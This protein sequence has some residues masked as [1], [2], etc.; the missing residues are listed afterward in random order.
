MP[1]T[2]SVSLNSNVYSAG[3]N[4]APQA[5]LTVYN[6]GASPVTVTSVQMTCQIAGTGQVSNVCLPGVPPIGPGMAVTVPALSSI[7]I[8]PW[9]IAVVSAAN[10]NSFQAV[11]QVDDLTPINPQPSQ[12]ANALIQCFA[13]VMG[14]DGS[15]NVSSPGGFTLSYQSQPPLGYQGGFLNFAGPNNFALGLMTGVL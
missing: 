15:I 5:T 14:S 7:N 11:N 2:C 8:G 12:P 4:P 1:L 10:V 9:P 13:T 3:Q 6:P